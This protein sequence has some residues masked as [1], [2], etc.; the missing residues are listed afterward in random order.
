M[1]IIL[2]GLLLIT[3]SIFAQSERSTSI[4]GSMDIYYPLLGGEIL[5]CNGYSVSASEQVG[6]FKVGFGLSYSRISIYDNVPESSF[7]P[8][9][10][11]KHHELKFLDFPLLF[12]FPH[13]IQKS[14]TFHALVGIVFNK[15]LSYI[16][17]RYYDNVDPEVLYGL[18]NSNDFGFSIR[19]GLKT[20]YNLNNN[21]SIGFNTIV[22][23]RVKSIF[24]NSSS[25]YIER[26]TVIGLNL[27]IGYSI[28]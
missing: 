13:V 9:L 16:Q 14:F 23:T 5:F 7:P 4:M 6:K 8:N 24:N 18:Q 25:N 27:F 15:Q 20:N 17:T 10:I 22:D 11:G 12:S 19:T 21:L 26:G 1:R 3:Q 2:I 28:F